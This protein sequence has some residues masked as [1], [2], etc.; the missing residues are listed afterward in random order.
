MAPGIAQVIVSSAPS[1]VKKAAREPLKSS[2]SLDDFAKVDLTSVIGTEFREGVQLAQFL[3][4][5]NSDDL[6]RDLALLGITVPNGVTNLSIPTGSRILQISRDHNQA[7]GTNWNKV[8]RAFRE[9][10]DFETPYSSSYSRIQRIW[11]LYQCHLCRIQQNL[12]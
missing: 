2:G 5:P 6:L 1:T 9:A 10:I 11:R 3:E 4:A 7:T 8:G 12:A